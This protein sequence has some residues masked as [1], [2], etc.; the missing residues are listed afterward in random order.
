MNK[1]KRKERREIFDFGFRISKGRFPCSGSRGDFRSATY[2]FDGA[3]SE[4]YPRSQEKIIL[5]SMIMPT[6]AELGE[7]KLVYAS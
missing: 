5:P 7:M 1:R 2:K 4:K 3:T 6:P